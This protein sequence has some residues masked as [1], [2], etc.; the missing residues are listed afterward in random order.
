M[1]KYSILCKNWPGEFWPYFYAFL[2][3]R[4]AIF[5]KQWILPKEN[6]VLQVKTVVASNGSPMADI[7]LQG[8][9]SLQSK[10]WKKEYL[11]INTVMLAGTALCYSRGFCVIYSPI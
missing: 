7:F 5:D 6:N 3:S 2:L 1:K 10:L 4:T 11:Q 9:E 8:I